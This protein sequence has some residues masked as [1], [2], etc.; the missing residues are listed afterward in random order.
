M[1]IL[2]TNEISHDMETGCGDA[3]IE[4]DESSSVTTK[5]EQQLT[6]IIAAALLL[7]IGL[8][9]FTSLSNN[10][11]YLPMPATSSSKA[12]IHQKQNRH[13]I[14]LSSWFEAL[15]PPT[16]SPTR[17]P[18][19]DVSNWVEALKVT[20]SPSRFPTHSPSKQPSRRPT[21]PPSPP[22]TID[23]RP[24]RD[25]YTTLINESFSRGYGL[26]SNNHSSSNVKHYLSTWGLNMGEA[27]S[28]VVRIIHDGSSTKK[29][30]LTSNEILLGDKEVT[31]IK[32]SFTFLAIGMESNDSL[33]LDYAF[34][35]GAITGKRCWTKA[36]FD[37]NGIWLE[38]SHEFATTV[39][40]QSLVIRLRVEGDDSLDDVLFDS[41]VVK[42]KA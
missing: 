18:T 27:R 9:T 11:N 7:L 13:L 41:V 1:S 15:S 25:G 20:P 6:P 42:G 28:G 4:S 26:F 37:K 17:K 2:A 22:P 8:V 21:S 10:T 19:I 14:D 40:V 23:L 5:K 12:S 24:D 39:D 29:A 34:D 35:D 36:M 32:V 38:M 16:H 30:E 33:C 31:R 3:A